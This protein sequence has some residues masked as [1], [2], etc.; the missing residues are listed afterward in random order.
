MKR[1]EFSLVDWDGPHA[2]CLRNLSQGEDCPG[3]VRVCSPCIGLDAPHRAGVELGVRWLSVDCF[4]LRSDLAPA[5]RLLHGDASQHHLGEHDGDLMSIDPSQLQPADGLV[6][7]PPCQ[8]FSGMGLQKHESDPRT[9]VVWRVARWGIVLAHRGCL[10]FIILENVPNIM[11]KKAKGTSTGDELVALLKEELPN[12]WEVTWETRS[13]RDSSL[14][15]ARLRLFIT[16]T[17]PS[18]RATATQCRVLTRGVPALLKRDIMEFLEAPASDA[19]LNADWTDLNVNQ[20]MN[21]LERIR[22]F[23]AHCENHPSCRVLIADVARDATTGSSFGEGKGIDETMTLRRNNRYLWCVPAPNMVHFF[24]PR[25]RLLKDSEKARLTGMAPQSIDMLS[26]LSLQT[27]I[28]NSIPVP[29]VACILAPVV[30]ALVEA[31]RRELIFPRSPSSGA[32]R[33]KRKRETE[34]ADGP[35]QSPE[36]SPNKQMLSDK[37]FAL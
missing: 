18:L 36:P 10:R 31:R 17:H 3:V 21:T 19:D 12:G 25:G 26:S 20:Q 24:G 1:P 32:D 35:D 29:L 2:R 9:Q 7:G 34:D 8:G 33:K 11:K 27:A 30:R 5:L 16:A 15:N 23:H 28:G 37:A 13:G 6:S 4:D 22:H 14:P